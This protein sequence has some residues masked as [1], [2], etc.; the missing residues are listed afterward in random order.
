M[1]NV[2]QDMRSG[3]DLG[4]C[5]TPDLPPR[6]EH[7]QLFMK[8]SLS[9]ELALVHQPNSSNCTWALV[10]IYGLMR[11]S[12]R[13]DHTQSAQRSGV[14]ASRHFDTMFQW[15]ARLIQQLV[16]DTPPSQSKLDHAYLHVVL[17]NERLTLNNSCPWIQ[18]L[19]VQ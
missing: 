8:R 3:F 12:G 7:Q 19:R 13:D 4:G 6:P 17:A 16:A 18:L 2:F 10:P 9:R 1:Q 5:H 15:R 14:S 11:S